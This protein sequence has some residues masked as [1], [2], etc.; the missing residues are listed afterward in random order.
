M[1]GGV[2]VEHQNQ[3]STVI[4]DFDSVIKAV[5]VVMISGPTKRTPQ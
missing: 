5:E 3:I 1:I 2:V 4:D